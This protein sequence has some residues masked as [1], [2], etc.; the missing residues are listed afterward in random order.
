MFFLLLVLIFLASLLLIL[1]VLAQNPKG[2]G[3]SS[4]FGGSGAA[5]FIGVKKTTDLLEKLTWGAA[6]VIMVLSIAA[7]MV[8]MP[9]SDL[10]DPENISPNIRKAQEVPTLFENEEDLLPQEEEPLPL[11]IDTTDLPLDISP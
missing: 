4:A 8:V 9:D 6:T 2:G 10:G 7:N 5:Q 3:L 11:S 1:A